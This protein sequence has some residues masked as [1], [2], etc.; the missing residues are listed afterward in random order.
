MTGRWYLLLIFLFAFISFSIMTMPLRYVLDRTGLNDWGVGWQSAQGTIWKGTLGG[1]YYRTQLIGDVTLDLEPSKLLSGKIGYQFNW[2]GALGQGEGYASLRD[3][4]AKIENVDLG[5]RFS[6]FAQISEDL[7]DLNG[8]ARVENL[9]LEIRD[10]TCHA[11]SGKVSID[12][13]SKLAGEYG[14]TGSEMLGDFSC[15]T[16]ELI[17]LNMVGIIDGSDLLVLE[18]SLDLRTGYNLQLFAETSDPELG[19]ALRLHGFEDNGIGF[20]YQ[21]EFPFSQS[22][23]TVG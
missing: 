22:L 19:A 18:S 7:R 14:L 23:Q 10:Q 4:A 3:G 16:E 5:I 6:G 13:L 8:N 9:S 21:R 2:S 15:Q 11:A 20:V 17:E 1:V 12:L